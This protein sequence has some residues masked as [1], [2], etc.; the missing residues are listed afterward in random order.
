MTDLPPTPRHYDASPAMRAFLGLVLLAVA[1]VCAWAVV[2]F[3]GLE[4]LPLTVQSECQQALYWAQSVER[5]RPHSAGPTYTD[6]IDQAPQEVR[7][8]WAAVVLST[9]GTGQDR[10]QPKLRWSESDTW[11]GVDTYSHP[12]ARPVTPGDLPPLLDG[13]VG[14]RAGP[15]GGEAE[16]F[17]F[18]C[19]AD[20]GLPSGLDVYTVASFPRARPDGGTVNAFEVT[21]DGA[22]P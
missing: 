22:E 8:N 1:G 14:L 20:L 4:S 19:A 15:D 6:R 17:L 11:Y 18:A 16:G 10:S 12:A 3:H 21:R 5:T 2:R 9:R 13:P 7:R